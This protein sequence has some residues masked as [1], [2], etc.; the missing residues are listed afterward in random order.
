MLVLKGL[1]AISDVHFSFIFIM[2][3]DAQYC[4]HIFSINY[5]SL[6]TCSNVDLSFVM[7]YKPLHKQ[8]GLVLSLQTDIQVATKDAFKIFFLDA[9]L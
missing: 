9:K 5:F 7:R 2:F 8:K 4:W 3:L 1:F 6:Q